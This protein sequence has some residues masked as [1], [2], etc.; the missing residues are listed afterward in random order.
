LNEDDA[1]DWSFTQPDFAIS[2]YSRYNPVSSSYNPVSSSPYSL[3]QWVDLEGLSPIS[4]ANQASM[5]L[6][7]SVELSSKTYT[8]SVPDV[9]T[10]DRSRPDTLH[11]PDYFAESPDLSL[12]SG[13]GSLDGSLATI[14]SSSYTA[15]L[16]WTPGATS[17]ALSSYQPS[18]TD[19]SSPDASQLITGNTS[20]NCSKK[21][22]YSQAL[23]ASTNERA[24]GQC[25]RSPASMDSLDRLTPASDQILAGS[26]HD[27]NPLPRVLRDKPERVDLEHA[28]CIVAGAL[29]AIKAAPD[30]HLSLSSELGRLRRH[31]HALK[32]SYSDNFCSGHPDT[33]TAVVEDL[34]SKLQVLVTLVKRMLQSGRL[35]SVRYSRLDPENRLQQRL[36]QVNC[37]RLIRALCATITNLEAL[38]ADST[39]STGNTRILT[40]RYNRQLLASPEDRHSH[41]VRLTAT[42]PRLD[43]IALPV[44]DVP[45]MNVLHG[46]SVTGLDIQKMDIP[47]RS[48]QYRTEQLE[49]AGLVLPIVM[50]ASLI[51][52]SLTN[53]T[54]AAQ[55][56]AQVFLVIVATGSLL[57]GHGPFASSTA[58][59]RDHPPTPSIFSRTT[60][61]P[62][63]FLSVPAA[64]LPLS[65]RSSGSLARVCSSSQTSL[66]PTQGCVLTSDI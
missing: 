5:L 65:T 34:A 56:G 15:S 19:A 51:A 61:P 20:Q 40:S 46:F 24:A 6:R 29:K 62:L 11:W 38:K 47:E 48:R 8:S 10:P 42:P 41:G 17:G 32:R 28:C 52:A 33:N 18:Q 37:R 26:L 57:A 64:L 9:N 54:T 55:L 49:I 30:E 21:R 1:F 59:L 39:P 31:L 16:D 36:W 60:V 13:S 44:L 35:T 58:T 43:F 3:E 25:G 12:S 2:G 22:L 66:P 27:H 45:S 14:S 63:S 23:Q 7:D 53:L 50:L 4:H